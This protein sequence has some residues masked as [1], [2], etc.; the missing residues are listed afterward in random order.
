MR[1]F[2]IQ[3]TIVSEAGASVLFYAP[4]QNW[5]LRNFPILMSPTQ[6]GFRTMAR[7]PLAELVKIDPKQLEMQQYQHDMPKKRMTAIGGVVRTA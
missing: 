6:C 3:Y 5:L 1:G 2:P 7:S 4:H